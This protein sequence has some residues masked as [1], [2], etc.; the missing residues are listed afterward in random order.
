M[1]VSPLRFV[2][3]P[4]PVL[5]CRAES[6][7]CPFHRV[8]H[9]R[10][11][12]RL[13]CDSPRGPMFLLGLSMGWPIHRRHRPIPPSS[14]PPCLPRRQCPCHSGSGS[15]HHFLWA[16]PSAPSNHLLRIA[17][18]RPVWSFP[19]IAREAAVCLEARLQD[20]AEWWCAGI[21]NR[22]SSEYRVAR[23]ERRQRGSG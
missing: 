13:A 10:G 9:L 23:G 20:N 21:R 1:S 14:F 18:F 3:N 19:Y 7:S 11:E 2:V 17:S 5:Q 6:S 22:G 15:Q 12:W 8:L 4:L 16:H